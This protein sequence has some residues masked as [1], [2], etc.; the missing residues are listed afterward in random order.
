MDHSIAI[1][2]IFCIGIVY[3]RCVLVN[4]H[5][6]VVQNMCGKGGYRVFQAELGA[7]EVYPLFQTKK[8]S[9][10]C[11]VKKTSRV[12]ISKISLPKQISVG[13]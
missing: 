7:A 9:C 12:A 3:F 10:K 8:N 6:Q 11:G 13:S 2:S 4:P 5:V 1:Y